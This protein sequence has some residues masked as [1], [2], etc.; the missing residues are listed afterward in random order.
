MANSTTD[1]KTDDVTRNTLTSSTHGAVV[2]IHPNGPDSD[3][4]VGIEQVMA[5]M[6]RNRSSPMTQTWL[7]ALHGCSIMKIRA[8]NPQG[9][10]SL[11]HFI[12]LTDRATDPQAGLHAMTSIPNAA[13][14]SASR[15]R[16][17]RAKHLNRVPEISHL[18][19]RA[20]H[21]TGMTWI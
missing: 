20:L 1:N 18:G 8:P 3:I 17:T 13:P 11:A 16:T 9:T 19:R 14:L 5:H 2:L 7:F 6:P 12:N 21:Q 4:R 15:L 10:V